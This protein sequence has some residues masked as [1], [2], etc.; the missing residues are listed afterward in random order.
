MTYTMYLHTNTPNVSKY[1]YKNNLAELQV[2]NPSTTSM[3]FEHFIK[4]SLVHI[5]LH[6]HYIM[7]KVKAMKT[8]KQHLFIFQ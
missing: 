5:V 4:S 1:K 8:Q 6:L 7:M 3:Y 2:E